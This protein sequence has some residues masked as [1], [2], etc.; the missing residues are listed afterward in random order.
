MK[1]KISFKEAMSIPSAA[2]PIKLHSTILIPIF[3]PILSP[4]SCKFLL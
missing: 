2:L 3:P 1:R 4:I